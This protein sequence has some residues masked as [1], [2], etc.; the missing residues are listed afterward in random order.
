MKITSSPKPTGNPARRHLALQ[1]GLMLALFLTAPNIPRPS[2]T[3]PF[4]LGAL[5]LYYFQ[6]VEK[7][8]RAV[9]R[10]SEERWFLITLLCF[11]GYLFINSLWSVATQAALGKAVFVA[12]IMGMTLIVSRA[13]SRQSPKALERTAHFAVIG[14]VIGT[15]IV[16]FEFLSGHTLAS[17]IYTYIPALRAGDKTIDVL[18]VI[19]GQLTNLPESEFRNPYDNIVIRV[20][21]AALNRNLSLL[22][23]LLWPALF[24][25]AN[26]VNPKLARLSAGIIAAAAAV[27]IFAGQ[28]QTAQAALLASVATFLAARH[29]T[30]LIHRGVLSI[31][32]I[33]LMLAL[34]LAAAPYK[35]GLHTK[36]WI[37]PSFRD[38]MIIWDFTVKQAKKTPWLGVG[39][40]STRVISKRLRK[41]EPDFYDHV[42]Y[43]RLG[44][45]SHNGFLQVWYELGAVGALFVLALGIGLLRA[46]KRMSENVRPYAYAVFVSACVVAAFG[47][48]LWQTWL[49]SGYALAII[50][51][52][53]MVSY[54]ER[55]KART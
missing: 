43:R 8:L 54:S 34:P 37:A 4:L 42:A 16:C 44:L 45:H 22:M 19:N 49:L 46:I 2:V 32:C 40:R 20:S 52:R 15:L 38:R 17:L 35:N 50:L 12:L 14:A 41:T 5:S 31:W 9:L 11:T 3:F 25:A 30:D 10:G 18:A 48:G 6:N 55:S 53:F 7:D 28:S 26:H 27:S 51:V 39:I 21:S 36:E 33:A 13:F 23:L 1:S 24:L 47:W 29:W